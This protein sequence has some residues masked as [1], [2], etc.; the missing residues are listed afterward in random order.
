MSLAISP[1]SLAA[2]IFTLALTIVLPL[3]VMI[4]LKIR[5]GKWGAF[6]TGAVTFFLFALVLEQILHTLVFLSPA[7]SAI[8]GSLLLYALYGGLAAGLFEETGRFLAF[9]FVLKKQTRPITA[10]SY[11]IGHGGAEAFLVVGMTMV[12][13]LLLLYMASTGL[14]SVLKLDSAVDTLLSTSAGMFLWSALERVSA[15][16]L[17]MANSVL[18]FTAVH[19]KKKRWLYPAAILIH[20]ASNFIAVIANAHLP[21]AAAEGLVFLIALLAVAWAT[22]IYKEGDKEGENAGKDR[23]P[24]P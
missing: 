1:A 10:L 11:G 8:Q 15:I 18:V 14:T 16:L 21:I 12:S 3:G 13:N 23:R 2:M 17:H 7:G 24:Q 6:L 9:R 22:R 20:A 5:G 19:D 4:F